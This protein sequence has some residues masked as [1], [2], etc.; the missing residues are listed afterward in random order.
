MPESRSCFSSCFPTRNRAGGIMLMAYKIPESKCSLASYVC[1]MPS[2]Q[3][4]GLALYVPQVKWRE[5]ILHDDLGNLGFVLAFALNRL[6]NLGGSPPTPAPS[7]SPLSPC[8]AER[9]S[10]MVFMSLP[11]RHFCFFPAAQK[12][13][14]P[15]KKHFPG[16]DGS[17]PG[18]VRKGQIQEFGSAVGRNC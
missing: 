6:C 10:D 4:H 16:V 14:K 7:P 11:G 2:N 9:L 3:S 17:W 1:K 5:R 15:V 12:N 8:T 13:S 18:L